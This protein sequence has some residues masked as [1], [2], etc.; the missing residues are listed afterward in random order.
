MIRRITSFGYIWFKEGK[1]VAC[2]VGHNWNG[3]TLSIQE[4]R[5]LRK[6]ASKS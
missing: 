2:Q 3:E 6:L 4:K 1:Q 5:I